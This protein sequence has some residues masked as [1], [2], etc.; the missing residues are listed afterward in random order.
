MAEALGLLPEALKSYDLVDL[1]GGVGGLQLL[2]QNAKFGLRLEYLAAILAG[3][4]AADGRPQAAK[5]RWRRLLRQPPIGSQQLTRLEDPPEDTFSASVGFERDVFR[6]VRGRQEDSAETT[7]LL[8][9]ALQ[10]VLPH[11]PPEAVQAVRSLS[12]AALQ[13]SEAIV[14]KAGIARNEPQLTLSPDYPFVPDAPAFSDLKRACTFTRDEIVGIVGATGLRSLGAISVKAGSVSYRLDNPDDLWKIHLRPIVRVGN[15]YVVAVPSALPLALTHTV[16]RWSKDLDV[17]RRVADEFCRLLAMTIDNEVNYMGWVQ[18]PPLGQERPAAGLERIYRFDRD[19]FAH[20]LIVSDDFSDY[21]EASPYSDWAPAGD[22]MRNRIDKVGAAI[23]GYHSDADVLHLVVAQGIG[24]PYYVA[25]QGN[26]LDPNSEFLALNPRQLS[27]IGRELGSDP[28]GLWKYARTVSKFGRERLMTFSELDLFAEYRNRN[29][30]LYFSDDERTPA[31]LLTPE[32]G[33]SLIVQDAERHD[34]HSVRRWDGAGV[35]KVRR[36]WQETRLPVYAP[37]DSTG[38]APMLLVESDPLQ[39][40]IVGDME[41]A[42]AVGGRLE[43]AQQFCEGVA[44]WLAEALPSLQPT[45]GLLSKTRQRL[46]IR[47]CIDEDPFDGGDDAGSPAEWVE[48]TTGATEDIN[49]LLRSGAV[50]ALSGSTNAGE[51]RILEAILLGIE[52]I[53][54][55]E[56]RAA[57]PIRVPDVIERHAPLGP[58]KWFVF[59][60]ESLRIP[61]LSGPLPLL[62]TLQDADV[63]DVLDLLGPKVRAETAL[64]PGEVPA[65]RRTQVLNSAV[66]FCFHEIETRVSRLRA[67]GLLEQLIAWHEAI[68]QEYRRKRLIIT[69]MLARLGDEGLDAKELRED[70]ELLVH[71]DQALRFLIEYVAAKPPSGDRALSLSELDYLVALANQVINKGMLSDAIHF[72]RADIGVSFLAS[73]RIGLTRSGRYMRGV[74]SFKLVQ[75]QEII[76]GAGDQF[77]WAWREGGEA[78]EPD[79]LPDLNEA[80]GEEFGLTMTEIAVFFGELLNIASEREHKPAWLPLSPLVSDVAT[81]LEWDE[82]KV[83][84]AVEAFAL[85]PRD[86]YFP[87]GF[88]MEAA[89]WRF[90]R[91]LSYVRRP[92]LLAGDPEPALIWGS[93][94]LLRCAPYVMDLIVSGQFRAK[95]SRMQSFMGRIRQMIGE[96]F[97]DRVAEEFEGFS[98][99]KVC[100]RAERFG[101]KRIERSPAEPL[102]DIDVLVVDRARRTIIAVE[103]KDFGLAKTP[104]E[105]A[106]EIAE[107]DNSP[108]STVRKHAERVAWL[109]RHQVQV[110]KSFGLEAGRDRWRT[111]ALVVVSEALIGVH[112]QDVPMEVLTFSELQGRLAG[113][114]F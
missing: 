42:K 18:M 70:L 87:S 64:P 89:P 38:E 113:D 41:G 108:G 7:E 97:N 46:M 40:W 55:V 36:A 62:R 90:N 75:S 21:S 68:V 63:E 103:T 4:E 17:L 54:P 29:N 6:I 100:R 71:S 45:L 93:R 101:G 44:Y 3:V 2:P 85:R 80:S 59:T 96:E 34:V 105:L 106:N 79:W 47:I 65:D 51:R 1:I 20:I 27:T 78:A 72:A 83:R 9:R 35:V 109:Q 53:L 112:I 92:L 12:L 61:L 48:A 19:K 52:A 74:E 13:L 84:A 25:I 104:A 67:Y 76:D 94:H 23:R 43:V 73:G 10:E 24:R 57:A 5:G 110:L 28:L 39:I 49:V 16:V 91:N 37:I 111:K 77:S 99:Y 56:L 26:G 95:S 32:L 50:Q 107:F 82:A 102:G 98:R 66:R 86:S 58:K 22:H 15:A 88:A 11:V 8:L 114:G 31:V 60:D 69:P 14:G 33:A 81:R 30:S